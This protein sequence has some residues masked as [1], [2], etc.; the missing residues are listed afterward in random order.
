MN[1]NLSL[2]KKNLTCG[3]FSLVLMSGKFLQ[4]LLSWVL[5]C[6]FKAVLASTVLTFSSLTSFKSKSLTTNLVGIT[7]F[8]LTTLMNDLTPVLLMNFFLLIDLLTVLGFLAI[9]TINKCG[10]LCFFYNS[11]LYFSSIFVVFGDNSLL[12][13]ES[14]CCQD[15][16]SSCFE[17]I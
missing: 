13:S 15:D 4:V 14:A 10:N 9:P 8:W 6:F 1:Q 5:N 16:D 2:L 3:A 17:T 12:S 7:W 11:I